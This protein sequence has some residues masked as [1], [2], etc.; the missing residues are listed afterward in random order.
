MPNTDLPADPPTWVSLRVENFA[1]ESRP[2][3]D[4]YQ[5]QWSCM[6]SR[7]GAV[8]TLS[9]ACSQSIADPHIYLIS[10]V[11]RA[12]ALQCFNNQT[13]ARNRHYRSIIVNLGR[14]MISCPNTSVVAAASILKYLWPPS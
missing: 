12:S 8:R 3:F 14:P 7:P 11:A 10:A 2:T 1:I 6:L 5:C 13:P 4:R 9:D